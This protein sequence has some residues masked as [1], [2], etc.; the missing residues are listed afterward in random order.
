[1][2]KK[3]GVSP[4]S[5]KTWD[6]VVAALKQIKSK[7]VVKY[8]WMGSWQQAEAVVCD[9][10]QFLGAF[11]GASGWWKLDLA[12]KVAEAEPD[13]RII[14]IDDDLAEQAADTGDW[15]AANPHVLVVAPDLFAGLTH[16]QLDEV[17]AWL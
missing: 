14:W 12:R 8:P 13:R 6:G 7:G 11:G 10:A 4:A 1:M 3:A 17:E 15:L 2:L 5:L 16:E 9:Y